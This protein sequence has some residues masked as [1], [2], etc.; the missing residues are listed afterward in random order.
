MADGRTNHITAQGDTYENA[1]G[2][3]EAAI[4]DGTKLIA[5]RKDS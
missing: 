2:A 4:P 5:I 1:K 3:L